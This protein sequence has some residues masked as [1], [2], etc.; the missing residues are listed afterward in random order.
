MDLEERWL[1]NIREYSDQDVVIALV[2]NKA[3][4]VEEA[5]KNNNYGK[6][7]TGGGHDVSILD[8]EEDNEKS[9]RSNEVVKPKPES[10]NI[11]QQYIAQ[12]NQLRQ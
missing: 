7:A 11:V 8:T 10:Q 12:Q 2:G 4:L 6:F 3:D 9:E 1:E 5:D